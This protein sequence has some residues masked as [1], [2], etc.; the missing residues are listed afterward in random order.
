MESEIKVGQ[1]FKFNLLSENTS[2]EW[3]AVVTRV[4]SNSEEGLGPEVNFYQAYW[5]EAHEI[6][7]T[8]APITLVF[9]RATDG[10]VYL[11]GCP[12]NITLLN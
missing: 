5:V 11:E 6:P 9:D 3:Q 1:R 10:N 8:E 4:L 12:V 2:Q 7:E